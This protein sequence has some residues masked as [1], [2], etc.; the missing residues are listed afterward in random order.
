MESPLTIVIPVF[1]E[2]AAIGATLE[3]LLAETERLGWRII[4]VNDGSV[5]RTPE[6]LKSYAGRIQIIHHPYNCGYGASLKSGI[7]AAA[8]EYVAIYDSD[9]QHQPEDLQRLWQKAQAYDMVVGVRDAASRQDIL[10]IPGKWFLT[11]AANLIVGQRISDINSGLRIFRRDFI[12]KIL[13]LLPE[14]FSFTSTCTVAALKMGFFVGYVPITTRK[15]VGS[16][17]VRQ[18]RHGF[19][20][21]MLILRLVILFSPLRIFFPVSAFL[22]F[23]GVLYAAYVIFTVRLTLAN[24]ALL[25]ILSALIIFFFGLLVDQI[26]AMRRERHMY[27]D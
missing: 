2:E 24:G 26:S 17:S 6:I 8:S 10:R 5:D 3:E 4:V 13:H 18:V 7:R 25:F 1:N 15:R 14:G 27:G 16:S 12:L 20:V 22:A 19:M 9:G 23:T 11:R 21:L